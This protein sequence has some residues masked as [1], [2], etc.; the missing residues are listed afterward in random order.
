MNTHRHSAIPFRSAAGGRNRF[1]NTF[2]W[3]RQDRGRASV[4]TRLRPSMP[5][6]LPFVFFFCLL[7]F[8]IQRNPK[9]RKH[10]NPQSEPVADEPLI[11]IGHSNRR[12]EKKRTTTFWFRIERDVDAWKG[13]LF[14]LKT[15]DKM[16]QKKHQWVNEFELDR[17]SMP[18]WL[19]FLYEIQRNRKR[20]YLNPS[21][22]PM[23]LSL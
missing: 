17:P 18:K 11:I 12:S 15:N 8:Y 19:P 9:K 10:L 13:T 22:L 6:R 14:L 3:R 16:L 7:L 21:L 4:P 20:K 1:R 5:K 2:L 23:S